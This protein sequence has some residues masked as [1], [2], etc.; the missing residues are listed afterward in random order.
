VVN[1]T[2]DKVYQNRE[3]HWPYREIDALGG[4]DP[5]S[6]SKACAE[7]VTTVYQ[8]NLCRENPDIV[9]AVVSLRLIRR[10]S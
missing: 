6:A 2:T 4:L 9:R 10:D 8:K 3:W 5:Y 7:L 1:V